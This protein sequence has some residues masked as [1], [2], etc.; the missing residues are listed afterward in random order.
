[1]AFSSILFNELK[2]AI[3]AINLFNKNYDNSLFKPHLFVD[4]INVL[5]LINKGSCKWSN[6]DPL[7]LFYVLKF[8]FINCIKVS[9]VHTSQ[10]LADKPSRLKHCNFPQ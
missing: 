5:Y 9:Y 3:L 4:N 10:N 6:I 2:A 8:F 7:F 1:M